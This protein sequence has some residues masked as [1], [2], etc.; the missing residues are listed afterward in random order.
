M[1]RWISRKPASDDVEKFFEAIFPVISKIARKVCISLGRD[2]NQMDLDEFARRIGVLLWEDNYQLLCSFKGESSLETWLFTIAKRN[3]LRW[4]RE[5]DG[6]ESLEDEPPG[7]FNA[8]PYIEE[9]LLQKERRR[10]HSNS[11]TQ[12]Q[13]TL[14]RLPGRKYKRNSAQK[15]LVN[16][17]GTLWG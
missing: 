1:S 11:F 5:Q 7:S 8:Q 12:K 3:I 2:P 10:M 9:M 14:S 13:Q 6:V 17:I 16:C 4:L 15:A